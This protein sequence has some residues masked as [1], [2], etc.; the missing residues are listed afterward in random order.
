[1]RKA[2]MKAARKVDAT[3]GVR[4]QR[5]MQALALGGATRRG[6]SA[7]RRVV[8]ATRKPAHARLRAAH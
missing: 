3:A 7:L 8:A 5:A 6:G 1:M 2:R 4:S